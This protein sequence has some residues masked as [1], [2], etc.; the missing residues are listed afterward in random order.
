MKVEEGGELKYGSRTE[1]KEVGRI[2]TYGAM[3]AL[4]RQALIN[5]DL[6]AFGTSARDW[7]RS[8][9]E[10]EADKLVAGGECR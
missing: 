3:F 4:T 1:R 8:A 5:D 7:G 2:Y 9:A 6:D 10:L